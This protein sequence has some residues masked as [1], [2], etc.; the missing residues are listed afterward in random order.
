MDSPLELGIENYL[1]EKGFTFEMMGTPWTKRTFVTKI[2][3]N[4]ISCAKVFRQKK[5][6]MDSKL[7]RK[8]RWVAAWLGFWCMFQKVDL[9]AK[10]ITSSI[11]V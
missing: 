8:D 3:P 7:P 1:S 9:P 4:I 5:R 6:E 11:V 10:N 2:D